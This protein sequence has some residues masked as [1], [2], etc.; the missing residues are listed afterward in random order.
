[1]LE[2]RVFCICEY[3]YW[4]VGEG[5]YRGG[6]VTRELRKKGKGFILKIINEG[7]IGL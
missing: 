5:R 2:A 1:M 3:L 7:G 6:F 4:G